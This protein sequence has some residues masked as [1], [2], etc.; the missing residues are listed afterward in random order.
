MLTCSRSC[1]A[2]VSSCLWVGEEPR[3]WIFNHVGLCLVGVCCWLSATVESVQ[4]CYWLCVAVALHHNDSL[5]TEER[6]PLCG[7][8][9]SCVAELPRSL[10]VLCLFI[11]WV[12][13][14]PCVKRVSY[15]K[16]R[17]TGT[18]GRPSLNVY[19]RWIRDPT[20][21]WN[22][23][24]L[25]GFAYFPIWSTVGLCCGCSTDLSHENG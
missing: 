12:R 9:S 21:S 10:C 22:G 4:G 5:Y 25:I 19:R 6:V 15:K 1:A 7:C 17:L 11:F 24:F 2:Q 23:G 8:H 16:S 20:S 18:E 3:V 13:G 14:R